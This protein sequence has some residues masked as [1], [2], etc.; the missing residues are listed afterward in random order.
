MS[1]KQ[2]LIL[3]GGGHYGIAFHLGLLKGLSEKGI[4]LNKSDYIVGTSAGSQVSTTI[5]SN[6]DW[7]T[8][9]N[10]QI[11]Q[12]VD[13]KTPISDDAMGE[14]FSEF[15]RIPKESQSDK[16]WIDAMGE[17]S[18]KTP[19]VI[20]NEE[21]QQMIRKRLGSVALEWNDKLNIVATEL[22]TSTRKIFNKDSGVDIIDALMASSALQ[23]VWPPVSIGDYHYYDGGSYSMENPDVVDDVHK[24]IVVSTNLPIPTP[25]KLD[26]LVD[27][28]KNQGK[29]VFIIKPDKNVV[30]ILQ[31]YEFNTMNAE[32][33]EEV[34]E[35]ALQQGYK[36]ASELE[37]FIKA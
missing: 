33:R 11:I 3:G 1:N 36:L 22:E 14:L 35:A 24:I 18:K 10:E 27:K 37:T 34:A 23:G 20:S 17:L 29:Q 26:E 28:M 2:A 19:V 15:E 21:R 4:E 25:Y 32:L 31:Q 16:A 8:I 9:W 12:Q 7:D 5:S 13:E 6:T 30:K